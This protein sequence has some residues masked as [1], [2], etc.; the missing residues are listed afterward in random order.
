MKHSLT[1]IIPLLWTAVAVVAVGCGASR[2]EQPASAVQV[3]VDAV[4]SRDA[5]TVYR[6]LDP[7]MR[8]GMSEDDFEAWFTTH[9]DMVLEQAKALEAQ[10]IPETVAVQ[11]EIPLD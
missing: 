6:M 8:M 4:Q 3:Y 9:Y 2:A 7:S 10:A 11:A 1:H 5:S